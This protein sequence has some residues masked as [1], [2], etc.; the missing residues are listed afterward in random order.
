MEKM[1]TQYLYFASVILFA[2]LISSCVDPNHRFHQTTASE[3]GIRHDLFY[4]VD[5]HSRY[6][7]IMRRQH[8]EI[9]QEQSV[10]FYIIKDKS[11]EAE[12]GREWPDLK[13]P[14]YRDIRLTDAEIEEIGKLVHE[15][16]V[17]RKLKGVLKFIVWKKN[18]EHVIYRKQL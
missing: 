4:G 3:A 1:N 7:A 9:N 11:I 16:V 14:G 6:K 15:V 8:P 2:S 17:S 10:F 13:K 18:K 12:M 5:N